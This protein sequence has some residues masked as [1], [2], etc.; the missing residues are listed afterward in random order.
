[1]TF[2]TYFIPCSNEESIIISK[3]KN[4]DFVASS[5]PSDFSFTCIVIVNNSIDGTFQLASAY[6]PT[7]FALYVIT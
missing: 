5:A 4:V 2:F 6:E 7:H 1:M 3:L